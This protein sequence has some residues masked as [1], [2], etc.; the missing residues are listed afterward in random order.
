MPSQPSDAF[1]FDGGDLALD[2]LNTRRTVRG[3]RVDQ[4]GTGQCV[5]RWLG[6]A[7]LDAGVAPLHLPRAR[8]LWAEAHRLRDAIHTAVHAH[9][10][11]T[12]PPPESLHAINR[13]LDTSRMGVALVSG[14]AGLE[15]TE[16]ELG[17][18]ALT[19]L[20]PVAR[21]A[22]ALLAQADPARIRQCHSERC[23]LWF[24]DTSK[25]GRRRWCSMAR[26]GNRAKVAKH[27]RK[28]KGAD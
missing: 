16:V 10:A 23:I 25:N 22:A 26:C 9:R 15:I 7:G 17:R 11:G 8:V 20:A 12:P 1:V 19:P 5:A 3:Q 2:F 14:A 6:E 4:L 28:S 27:Y 18:E 13:V 21:A 24:L